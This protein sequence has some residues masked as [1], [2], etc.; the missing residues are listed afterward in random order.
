MALRMY[1][2]VLS[3]QGTTAVRGKIVFRPVTQFS[4]EMDLGESMGYTVR[5]AFLNGIRQ[6]GGDEADTGVYRWMS[7]TTPDTP[8]S[9]RK[10]LPRPRTPPYPSPQDRWRSK[11][12]T[13]SPPNRA[14]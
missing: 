7:T 4:C 2:C 10:P 8:R 5:A 1:W 6:A 3:R 12:T 14:R 13:I 9:S 11:P